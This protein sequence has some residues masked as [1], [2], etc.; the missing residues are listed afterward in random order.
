MGELAKILGLTEEEVEDLLIECN[1]DLED[2][3]L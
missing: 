1:M 2:I 3:W